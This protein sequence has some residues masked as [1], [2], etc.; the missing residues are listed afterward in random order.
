MN[1]PTDKFKAGLTKSE[2]DL[3][4]NI[5]DNIFQKK[6]EDPVKEAMP[7]LSED[8]KK[9]IANE[10]DVAAQ[11]TGLYESKKTTKSRSLTEETMRIIDE[12]DKKIP[13]KHIEKAL[14]A[15]K[16]IKESE[17]F[18]LKFVQKYR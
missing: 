4:Q 10:S 2:I 18:L 1:S 7:H 11:I 12:S 13:P 5:I 3:S 9:E 15:S 14:L 17:R 16:R 6:S 8:E